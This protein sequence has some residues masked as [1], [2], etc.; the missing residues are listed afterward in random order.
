[1]SEATSLSIMVTCAGAEADNYLASS[2]DV[3]LIE[4]MIRIHVDR[5][6]QRILKL[7]PPPCC[8]E[9]L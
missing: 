1:M 4:G 9:V 7:P 5:L 3:L 8:N 6:F 2:I